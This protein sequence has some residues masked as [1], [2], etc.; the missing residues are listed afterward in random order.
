[1][2]KKNSHCYG[3]VEHYNSTEFCRMLF[4]KDQ[5]PKMYNNKEHACITAYLPEAYHLPAIRA[6][7]RQSTIVLGS[8]ASWKNDKQA[9]QT[10]VKPGL[11][12]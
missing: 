11:I 4:I 5:L 3:I 9:S 10:A 2:R 7:L 12:V 6:G 8:K 1:M